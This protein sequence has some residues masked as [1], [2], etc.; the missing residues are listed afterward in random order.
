MVTSWKN[1]PSYWQFVRRIHWS[2]V[3]SP[4]KGQWHG[5]LMFS[6]IYVQFYSG[7]NVLKMKAFFLVPMFYYSLAQEISWWRHQME[8]ASALPAFC[9]GN[10][11]VP[12]EFLSQRS[13]MQTFGVFLDLRLNKRLTKQ[14]WGWLFEMPSRSIWCHWNDEYGALYANLA[15]CFYGMELVDLLVSFWRQHF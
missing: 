9:T 13:V 14:S 6:L 7:P 5:A 4:H 11:P 2:P 8:T 3:N 1:F 12:G 15:V 10:S